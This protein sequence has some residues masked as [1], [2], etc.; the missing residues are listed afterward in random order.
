MTSLSPPL[1]FRL[2][3]RR[4]LIPS[5][6]GY[7]FVCRMMY[8]RSEEQNDLDMPPLVSRISLQSLSSAEIFIFVL[9]RVR[10]AL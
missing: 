9:Q 8:S 6:P 4:L 2:V 3:C 1:F 10:L 5:M 7:S